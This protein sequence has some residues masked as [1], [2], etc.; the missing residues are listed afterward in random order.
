MVGYH[1]LFLNLYLPHIVLEKNMI[2][3]YSFP[4]LFDE[5]WVT[6]RWIIWWEIIKIYEKYETLT[7]PLA[8]LI[9]IRQLRSGLISSTKVEDRIL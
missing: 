1:F 2:L 6:F 3:F 8:P 7:Y 5:L 4:L 9:S